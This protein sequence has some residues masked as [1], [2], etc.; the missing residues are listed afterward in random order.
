[1]LHVAT[2]PGV[3]DRRGMWGQC[4]G[5]ECFSF[6]SANAMGK[7]LRQQ[8]RCCALDLARFG[9]ACAHA[10]GATPIQLAGFR[11]ETVLYVAS[12]AAVNSLLAR[13]AGL[14][15]TAGRARRLFFVKNLA[16]VT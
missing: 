3:V 13:S 10:G 12:E 9:V 15:T 8:K 14:R 16:E 2:G 7:D 11:T 5:S 1:M 4:S 6:G